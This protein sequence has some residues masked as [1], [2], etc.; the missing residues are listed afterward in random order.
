M[1]LDSVEVEQLLQCLFL[2]IN[3]LYFTITQYVVVVLRPQL[4]PH[5]ILCK[6]QY[7]CVG[8]L[9]RERRLRHLQLL[10]YIAQLEIIAI[11]ETKGDFSIGRKRHT[12]E[13][14]REKGHEQV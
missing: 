10:Q 4:F 12:S 1:N 6:C 7:V 8:V 9:L 2:Q 5:L 13:P 14:T 11:P 3:K